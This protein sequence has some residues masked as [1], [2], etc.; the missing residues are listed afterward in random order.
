MLFSTNVFTK[1]LLRLRKIEDGF[2]AIIA[3]ADI[4]SEKLTAAYVKQQA[5]GYK[6]TWLRVDHDVN[7]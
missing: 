6:A 7:K 2:P 3:I 1:E 5:L 4:L